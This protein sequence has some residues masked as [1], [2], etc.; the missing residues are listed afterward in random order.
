MHVQSCCFAKLN[1]LLFCRSRWRRREKLPNNNNNNNNDKKTNY[2][3][4]PIYN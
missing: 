4:R 2:K 1:L 3:I